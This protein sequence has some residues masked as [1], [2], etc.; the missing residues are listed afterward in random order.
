MNPPDPQAEAVWERTLPQIRATRRKRKIRRIAGAACCA[1][2]LWFTL[3]SPEAPDPPTA[4]SAPT[5]PKIETMAVMR[6]DENGTIRLEEIATNE[7]GSIE[8][9][10]GETPLLPSEMTASGL[11][12]DDFP[13]F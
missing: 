10:F 13:W 9:A 6:M 11:S 8:L 5:L 2:A 7:L 12:S 3:Q 1:I 4:L